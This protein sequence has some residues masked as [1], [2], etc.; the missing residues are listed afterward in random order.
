MTHVCRFTSVRWLTISFTEIFYLKTSEISGFSH[1]AKLKTIECLLR[2]YL[3]AFLELQPRYERYYK[4]S[5]DP[6]P[7]RSIGCPDW[8]SSPCVLI[9]KA[10]MKIESQLH[11]GYANYRPL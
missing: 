6:P 3:S 11:T 5:K 4:S 10:V 1:D 8:I 9:D 2:W 7:S